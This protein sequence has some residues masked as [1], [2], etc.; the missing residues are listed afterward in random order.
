MDTLGALGTTPKIGGPVIMSTVGAQVGIITFTT[1]GFDC[2]SLSPIVT[3]T[4][5]SISNGTDIMTVNNLVYSTDPT[6][7]NQSKF[8]TGNFYIGGDLILVGTESPGTYNIG[9]AY[10]MTIAF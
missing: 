5:G 10:T 7:K 3:F 1:P 6:K 8:D 2:S 4:P 9:A